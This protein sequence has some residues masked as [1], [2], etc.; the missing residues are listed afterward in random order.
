VTL[1]VVIPAWNE[2]ANI[3]RAI[4]RA[5]AIEPL[6]VIVVDGGSTDGTVEIARSCCCRL[7]ES[8]RGR[9]LQQNEGARAASGETLLFLHAD[10]WLD[11]SG[12]RQIATALGRAEVAAGAFQQ[13]IEATGLV[14]RL[15]ERGNAL[16]VRLFGMAYGDQGIFIRRA[17]F[18]QL[19][20]FPEVRL[21]EDW[22]LMR[23]LRRIARPVLLRGPLYVS[24]RRWQKHGALRQ[25]LRNRM[26]IVAARLGV[27]PNRLADFYEPHK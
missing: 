22:L 13:Q 14:Y 12:G 23:R 16:R 11:P 1:S 8:A 4:E 20:G 27:S 26:L 10:T 17:T 25:T 7:L 21:M 18:E 24:A 3:A 6:E 2:S 19:G 15:L 9:A 5:W